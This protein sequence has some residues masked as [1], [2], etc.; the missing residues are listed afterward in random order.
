MVPPRVLGCLSTQRLLLRP[1]RPGDAL[2]YRQLWTERD[3]RVPPHR[4]IDPVGRPT[5]AAI[6]DDIRAESFAADGSY[7]L[8]AV[9][10]QGAGDVIGYCGLVTG[11]VTFPDGSS[12]TEPELAY[13]LLR[14][15]R[16]HG[17]ATEAGQAVVDWAAS[18]GC[19]RLWA[20]VREW[21]TASLR[22]LEKLGF[23]GTGEHEPD[24]GHGASLIAVRPL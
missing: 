15:A 13:E 10:R 23:H 16:G 17:Y 18:A 12:P 3:H 2:V 5:V 21:N 14:S 22:V 11:G 19:V 1:G 4:R 8:L 9:Q 7:R 6:A 20:T 24:D